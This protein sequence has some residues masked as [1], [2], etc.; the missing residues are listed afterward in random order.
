VRIFDTEDNLLLHPQNRRFYGNIKKGYTWAGNN[1]DI[2]F[3]LSDRQR[4]MYP[5]HA[6]P[7]FFIMPNGV[8][9]IFLRKD[10]RVPP[11]INSIKRPQAIYVGV[12]QERMD[13]ELMERV[14]RSLP[15]YS[16]IFVGPEIVKSYFDPLKSMQNVRF[17]GFKD[18]K[19][20]PAYINSADVCIIPH[21]VNRF[22]DSQNPLKIYEYL[23]CGKPVVSTSV[24]GTDDFKGHIYL[25]DDA[26]SFADSIRRAVAENSGLR[27]KER[28]EA[29]RQNTWD[30]RIENMIHV[31]N[32]MSH[33]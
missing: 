26:V 9:D 13:V 4:V 1:A 29:A 28:R 30:I 20:M 22:T 16:F 8:D 32:R 6:A 23:A 31:M 21:K 25:A 12:L 15:E 14:I 7:R 33:E 17:L 10:T 11:D 24:A 18:Y 3:L 19:S 27:E 2:I 5:A